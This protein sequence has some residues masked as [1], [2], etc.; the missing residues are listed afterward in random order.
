MQLRSITDRVD[1]RPFRPFVIELDNGRQVTVRRQENIIFFPSRAQLRDVI[2]YD[3]ERDLRM[4]FE[5]S[6]V[7]AL[8]DA[9]GNVGEGDSGA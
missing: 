9:R 8:L 5:P 2:A 3:E 6:A 1:R 4:I 7:S